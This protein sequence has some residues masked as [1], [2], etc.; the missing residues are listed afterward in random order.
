MALHT[1]FHVGEITL[2]SDASASTG[3]EL[4]NCMAHSGVVPL[5]G[6]MRADGEGYVASGVALPTTTLRNVRHDFGPP[7]GKRFLCL[8]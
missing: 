7:R 4:M 1:P 6:T 8:A 2:C 5:Y 3:V